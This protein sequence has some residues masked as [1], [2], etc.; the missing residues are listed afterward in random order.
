MPASTSRAGRP[1][2]RA[3]RAYHLGLAVVADGLVG[4]TLLLVWDYQERGVRV[5]AIGTERGISV[6]VTSGHRRVLIESGGDGN[7]LSD[8]MNAYLTPLHRDIDITLTDARAGDGDS[9]AARGSGRRW[10]L[11]SSATDASAAIGASSTVT[12]PNDV[13]IDVLVEPG[14]VGDPRGWVAAI[15]RGSSVIVVAGGEGRWV[16]A[17]VSQRGAGIVIAAAVT[18]SFEA[19]SAYAAPVVLTA[20]RDVAGSSPSGV[21]ANAYRV[22]PSQTMVF[23]FHERGVEV[24]EALED[25][26]DQ[27][28]ATPSASSRPFAGTRASKSRR[29]SA[30]SSSERSTSRPDRAIAFATRRAFA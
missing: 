2:T 4:I 25:R 17:A 8:G 14:P 26:L 16:S 1:S 11:G 18:A 29:M 7:A 9:P 28:A 6:L 23:R 5:V 10:T 22:F 15:R 12:M 20:D 24:P 3:E 21:A 30:R 19:T 13:S 27:R